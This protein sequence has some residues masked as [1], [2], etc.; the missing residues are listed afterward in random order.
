[1]E[2]NIIV[3]NETGIHARPASKIVKE[4]AKYKSD[5]TIKRGDK[6]YNAK[7]V[8]GLMAMAVAKGEEITLVVQGEDEEAA[9]EGLTNLILN[10]LE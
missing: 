3:S 6:D 7:S 1:M 4:A 2:R 9:M 5:I 10:D 8:L